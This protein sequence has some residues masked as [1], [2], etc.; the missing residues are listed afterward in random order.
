MSDAHTSGSD[1]ANGSPSSSPSRRRLASAGPE[2][3]E[4]T[5]YADASRARCIRDRSLFPAPRQRSPSDRHPAR[6]QKSARPAQ[7]PN[8]CSFAC[9]RLS[10]RPPIKPN[11]TECEA[12]PVSWLFWREVRYSQAKMAPN[13]ARRGLPR[14]ILP[15]WRAIVGAGRASA[16]RP[17]GCAWRDPGTDRTR[18]LPA[19]RALSDGARPET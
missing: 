18:D 1:I 12:D 5:G 7:E 4:H 13:T 11:S 3:D 10:A 17:A 8:P 15:N 16:V 6:P 14:R 19:L 2:D 9:S